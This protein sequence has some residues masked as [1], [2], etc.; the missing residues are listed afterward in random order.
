MAWKGANTSEGIWWNSFDG[1]NWSAQ[2]RVAGVGTSIGPSLAAFD[3]KLYMAWPGAGFD[4]DIYW[5]YRVSNHWVAQH[6]VG[7]GASTRGRPSFAVSHDRLYLAWKEVAYCCHG[8]RRERN[9]TPM[10]WTSSP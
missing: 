8:P 4:H 1:V 9:G 3:G 6:K 7:H 2:H 10:Y 5:N